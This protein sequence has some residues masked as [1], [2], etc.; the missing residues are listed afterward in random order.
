MR[1][2]FFLTLLIM[3]I[4]SQVACS[5]ALNFIGNSST[6]WESEML[7]AEGRGSTPANATDPEQKK[8]FCKTISHNRRLSQI[9]G[10][11]R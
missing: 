3:F 4:F 8:I 1:K 11:S 2:N 7:M 10:G 9:G 5:Q 6:W